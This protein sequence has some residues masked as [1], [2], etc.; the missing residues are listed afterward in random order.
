M[1]AVA[2]LQGYAL[3]FHKRGRDGSGKCD[4]WR[5]ESGADELWGVV[6][7]VGEPDLERLDVVEGSGYRRVELSV[8]SGEDA[9]EVQTYVARDSWI[10]PALRPFEW[11]RDLVL[12][13]AL[14]NGL[15]GWWRAQIEAV[16]TERDADGERSRRF[17]GL[18]GLSE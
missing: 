3:R 12:A 9:L 5:I 2:R 10:D 8:R 4:A 18:L 11:Y 13:G 1:R 16:A 7:E 17:R 14:E 15:P 6:W